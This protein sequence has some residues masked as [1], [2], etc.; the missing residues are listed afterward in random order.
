MKHKKKELEYFVYKIYICFGV[1]FFTILAL[2][3]SFFG[4]LEKIDQQ[5]SDAIYQI[6]NYR[7]QESVVRIIAIDNK[8]VKHLGEFDGWS[9]SQTAE[10]IALLNSA[11]EAPKVIGLG[12]DYSETKE[13]TGDA[14]LIEVC[15]QN[16]NVCISS[17]VVVGNETFLQ[18]TPLS[19]AEIL[20]HNPFPF[21]RQKA[22]DTM[23]I[24]DVSLP[25]AELLPY[26]KTGVINNLQ[27]GEDGYARTAVMEVTHGNKEY[28][29]FAVAVYKMYQE[30]IGENAKL[31]KVDEDSVFAFFY[32]KQST[33]YEIYSFYDVLSGKVD[34]KEFAGNIVLIGDYTDMGTTFKAPNQQMRQM[35]H[36]EVQANIMDALLSQNTGKPLSYS[37]MSGFYALFAILF[38][39]TTSYSSGKRTFVSAV[40]L[41]FSQ[42]LICA[43]L[44][45]L[46]YYI[47]ILIPIILVVTITIFNLLVRVVMIQRNN[48]QLKYAF[49]KYVDKSI[50]NEIVETG[51][52]DVHVGGTKRDIAVLFVDIRGYT[53][54]SENLQPEQMVDILNKYLAIAAYAVQKNKGTL[55]KFIGDAAMA[56]FNSPVDLED[57]EYRAVCAAWD[58]LQETK[59]LSAF[60]QEKYGKQITFG[61]GIHCGVAVTGNIG[62]EA[63][64]DYTAI[65]DTVNTASRLEGIAEAGQILISE[66]M[67]RRI[68][69]RIHTSYGGE[70]SLKGKKEKV[71]VYI[72]EG[73]NLESMEEKKTVKVLEKWSNRH[74]VPLNMNAQLYC[75]PSLK[76]LHKYEQ[77]AKEYAAAFE[78]N[79]FFLPELLDNE[80][81][82]KE[83][84]TQYMCLDRDRSKD[85]L[86]GAF[87]DICVNSIDAAIFA[88]SDLRIHQCMDIAAQMGL[89]A[90]IFHTNFIVNFKLQSYLDDW[91]NRNAAYWKKILQEYPN[92][93]IYLENMFDDTPQLLTA[94]AER[95]SGEPRFAVCLDLAHAFISGSSLNSWF[96]SMAPYV[97]H[98]HVNDN[99]KHEDLHHPV[100]M[101]AFPWSEFEQ[102]VSTLERKPGVLIEVRN[103]EDLQKSVVYMKE[104]RIYPFDEPNE[105]T[106]K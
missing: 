4:N 86:H 104:H 2:G 92:Q 34:L 58:F 10:M 43:I 102:W 106:V 3:L 68:G 69:E 37:F 42:I 26:I 20:E 52:I 50:V 54:L 85:T 90:V 65:G 78:Y 8:T 96:A 32:T 11:E 23:D 72:V 51:N 77:F 28:D 98:L 18:R 82:K 56:V 5:F 101:G 84:I 41:I 45:F 36:M 63:R 29:S 97:A 64:M 55:D 91:V 12:L 16:E 57:Y 70:V 93:S 31:P 24:L 14:K 105:Q 44:N 71:P 74:A 19:N 40:V 87:L 76:E 22:E 35:Q 1:V 61:I 94:L 53:T 100:G 21:V 67:K 13:A 25:Y 30:A 75:I 7:K 83:I 33:D 80:E 89:K 9:R 73:V 38:F 47:L 46:G 27:I 95:M 39:V 99:N 66:E 62:C 79:E 15:E 59:Q 17:F 49:K 88:V 103:F 60:C 6:R 81:K 48:Y